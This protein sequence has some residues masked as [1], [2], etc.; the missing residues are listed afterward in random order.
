MNPAEVPNT[1]RYRACLALYLETRGRNVSFIERRMRRSGYADFTRRI[2]YS[3]TE[4]G[5]RKPGWIERFGWRRKLRAGAENAGAGNRLKDV[6]VR[7]REHPERA[8]LEVAD[9]PRGERELPPCLPDLHAW[10]KRV[11][12]GMNW[13]W[14]HLR[15]ICEQLE[16]VTTGDCKRL[17]IFLPP[18]H[19]KSELV[20]VRYAAWRIAR[21]PSLNVILG[22][23][24]QRL[25]DRFSR[26]VRRVLADDADIRLKELAATRPSGADACPPEDPDLRTSETSRCSSCSCCG[27]KP[28]N[29]SRSGVDRHSPFSRRPANSVS[30]WETREGGTFRAVGVGAGVTGFGAGLVVI[31][32]PVKSRA[33]AE[34]E[35]Y[36][37][38]VWEWFNDDLYTRLEPDGAI[39]LIQTRWHEDDLAGR[40]LREQQDGGEQWTVINLPALAE[41]DGMRNAECGIRSM[42]FHLRPTRY[43]RRRRRP[44]RTQFRSPHSA[45]RIR[46][47]RSAVKQV[48]P[49]APNAST[50]RL[51]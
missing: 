25:A 2:L 13:D 26:K 35:T 51:F 24:N 16:R 44:C 38:R 12:P 41:E 7:L 21:D 31:D 17:M 40:L 15:Y 4:K 36:R 8:A 1:D 34:S 49:S 6:T 50:K 45:L 19:G 18:R 48:R 39:I 43:R 46:K 27:S 42:K 29:G 22:S 23:Y 11:S 30:E 9:P 28:S 10:L 33:E 47:I 32:D 20:S 14:R 37:D 3:R 5:T